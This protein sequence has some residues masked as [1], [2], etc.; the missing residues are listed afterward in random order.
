MSSAAADDDHV[1][2]WRR[3]DPV[4]RQNRDPTGQENGVSVPGDDR[5]LDVREHPASHRYDANG[6]AEVDRLGSIIDQ[7]A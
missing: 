3:V 1:A 4:M 6:A 2:G 7:H 5:R